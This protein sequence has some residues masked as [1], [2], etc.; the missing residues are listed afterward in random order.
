MDSVFMGVFGVLPTP[1]DTARAWVMGSGV[2]LSVDA[3]FSDWF[4]YRPEDLPG[5]Y[6]STLVSDA[7]RMEEAFLVTRNADSRFVNRQSTDAMRYRRS[8][9][10]QYLDHGA[11][12]GLNHTGSGPN[13]A[14]VPLLPQ[15][16]TSRV[17]SVKDFFI[18][19]KFAGPVKCNVDIVNGGGAHAHHFFILSITREVHHP[20]MVTDGKGKLLH[21]SKV[22]ADDIGFTVVDLLGEL[23]DKAWDIILPEP[24]NC[25]H[26][27]NIMGDLSPLPPPYSCRS[28]LS[29]CLL[30]ATE[31]GPKPVPYR[32]QIKTRKQD[33]SEESANIVAL[34]KVT[35]EQAMDERRIKVITDQNGLITKVGNTSESLFGFDPRIMVGRPLSDFVNVFQP[36]EVEVSKEEAIRHF[37]S[38]LT[39][40]A[41]RSLDAP[42]ES[43]RVG[44]NTPI[45][46]DIIGGALLSAVSWHMHAKSTHPAVM[47]V[48]VHFGGKKPLRAATASD[49]QPK[50]L[51][52]KLPVTQNRLLGNMGGMQRPHT[53]A[54]PPEILIEYSNPEDAGMTIL[55]EHVRGL[56]TPMDMRSSARS[57]G[58]L[59]HRAPHS[60]DEEMKLYH[61]ELVVVDADSSLISDEA[62]LKAA[63]SK[64]VGG[65]LLHLMTGGQD[66][67]L[68]EVDLWKADLMTGL[69]YIDQSGRITRTS[70]KD[71][72]LYQAGY[73]LGVQDSGLEGL[74]FGDV[75]P[76]AGRAI[77][78]LFLK[79][80]GQGIQHTSRKGGLKQERKG[81]DK[82]FSKKPG[83]INLVHLTHY[84]DGQPLALT[85]QAVGL[86]Q[87][88]H[89]VCLILR[90]YRPITGINDFKTVLKENPP[91]YHL[92]VTTSAFNLSE[93]PGAIN[94]VH[95]R[96][97]SALSSAQGLPLTHVKL[98]RGSNIRYDLNDIMEDSQK[99]N[100]MILDGTEVDNSEDRNGPGTDK[101]SGRSARFSAATAQ[102]ELRQNSGLVP[103]ASALPP[104]VD[105]MKT[106]S[107]LTSN[108]RPVEEACAAPTLEDL[109]EELHNDNDTMEHEIRHDSSSS[110]DIGSDC[111]KQD[112]GAMLA[113]SWVM[114]GGQHSIVSPYSSAPKVDV[115]VDVEQENVTGYSSIMP[116]NSTGMM[117]Q[118]SLIRSNRVSPLNATPSHS[119]HA[120]RKV[121]PSRVLSAEEEREVDDTADGGAHTADGCN[122]MIH[123]KPNLL[124]SQKKGG[125]VDS[126]HALPA[127][128]NQGSLDDTTP[129]EVPLDPIADTSADAH[130]A[131]VQRGHRYKRV[132]KILGSDAALRG[133]F[134]FKYKAYVAIAFVAVV[135]VAAFIA[136]LLL[137]GDQKAGI[138]TLSNIGRI[139][140]SFGEIYL[141]TL[142]L[143]I[144]FGG[145]GAQGLPGLQ[146]VADIPAMLTQLDNSCNALQ[147]N[148]PTTYGNVLLTVDSSN[149]HD[150]WNTP[151][152]SI[153]K[154]SDN[155]KGGVISGNSQ[156]SFWD[157]AKLFLSSGQN[158]YQ[159]AYQHNDTK[160]SGFTWRDWS[161]VDYISQNAE[162]LFG[163]IYSSLG[164]VVQDV[165]A[166][167]D[168]VNT[169]QLILLVLVGVICSLC[170]TFFMF[171]INTQVTNMR[172]SLYSPF[173]VIPMGVVRNM[174]KIDMD[175]LMQDSNNRL[176]EADEEGPVRYN[177][178]RNMTAQLD[179]NVSA[180]ERIKSLVR[181]AVFWRKQ[182]VATS[183]FTSSSNRRTLVVS[184]R[185]A[186]YMS[187]PFFAWGIL[188][189]TTFAVGH[190]NLGQIAP[191]IA[192]FNLVNAVSTSYYRSLTMEMN[193][194]STDDLISKAAQRL[195]LSL[196]GNS[197]PTEYSALLYGSS[198]VSN[199]S[200][201]LF[202]L[203]SQGAASP[204]SVGYDILYTTT[205]CL[206][207]NQSSCL[208]SN[209]SLF[210]DAMH[211]LDRALQAYMDAVNNTMSMK[212]LNPTLSDPSMYLMWNL[213][214][215]IV[216]GLQD[217]NSVYYDYVTSM[218]TS[219][220]TIHIIGLALSLALMMYFYFFMLRPFLR[221]LTRCRRRI[222]YLLSTL[223]NDVDIL[224][225][226][227][228]AV[229]RTIDG[230]YNPD[231]QGGTANNSGMIGRSISGVNSMRAMSSSFKDS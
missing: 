147:V 229:A 18:R 119:K 113:S 50:A 54:T 61:N 145:Q 12:Q 117:R 84:A 33:K 164:M 230:G 85:V 101:I 111:P 64:G 148:L 8:V 223:P 216:G 140:N 197:L 47:Q 29:V 201:I 135:S 51:G 218:Y 125:A 185:T 90:L 28:G 159:N 139:S 122:T 195:S 221:E 41:I 6:F 106:P 53:C 162:T 92:G 127:E 32:L 39:E 63:G 209:S 110:S 144:L 207:Q 217:L 95:V 112:E 184:S 80:F 31:E 169:A 134:L 183:S 56:Q 9:D 87:Q 133:V 149:L 103:K 23:A 190:Y 158:I 192:I 170:A 120:V 102:A 116:M 181:S 11:Q 49:Q 129:P 109:E 2:V 208:T 104:V 152:L 137:L 150:I 228:K 36:N 160:A 163:A 146:T 48:R 16:N 151:Y 175:M 55:L 19:H 136:M 126:R 72:P 187:L 52:S 118:S 171:Y 13:S 40:L 231:A 191:P 168:R 154:Y 194:S 115:A 107:L 206:R 199:I 93:A 66:S 71:L 59:T 37:Q 205:D 131:D 132:A 105:G 98:E 10:K 91:G 97:S 94:S 21:V 46:D 130:E 214:P 141:Q 26:H 196:M 166:S 24:F 177:L 211:G 165:V 43:F 143:A 176:K 172:F 188:M 227:K 78:N 180:L 99:R 220:L 193:L 86:R 27:S 212:G 82:H 138:T 73:M 114:S 174:V 198:G 4:G 155:L 222:A 123:Q 3:T 81:H 62:Y 156:L 7:T 45:S 25:L 14:L 210:Q 17:T 186:T 77:E 225:L 96:R 204:G 224:G 128:A 157:A 182:G 226:V 153:Y 161:Y 22:I 44:V 5:A 219:V 65:G 69:L 173:V 1:P 35:M 70:Y 108:R 60:P 89:E 34:E 189:I 202:S 179:S 75:M 76:E 88:R 68:L 83:A 42:G 15:N 58:R 203:A 124:G 100:D 79:N 74:R 20:L 215:D 121:V 57:P 67:L 178:M 167:A 30:N 213:H 142:A 200:N 38:I